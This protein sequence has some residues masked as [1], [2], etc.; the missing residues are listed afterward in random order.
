VLADRYVW[1]ADS[2]SETRTRLGKPDAFVVEKEGIES[3]RIH[4]AE[5]ENVADLNRFADRGGLNEPVEWRV[6]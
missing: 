4:R 5:L 6:N 1:V 3:L 2:E